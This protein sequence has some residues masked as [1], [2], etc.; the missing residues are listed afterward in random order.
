MKKVRKKLPIGARVK[1]NSHGQNGGG[2]GGGGGGSMGGEVKT[3]MKVE[4]AD[5]I[6]VEVTTKRRADEGGA[7]ERKQHGTKRQSFR[8]VVGDD[9][10]VCFENV[11]T[12]ETVL[13]MPKDGELVL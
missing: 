6:S 13:D 3:A 5:S 12:G 10:A 2:G 1:R 7:G 11:E 4:V 9:N 8:K